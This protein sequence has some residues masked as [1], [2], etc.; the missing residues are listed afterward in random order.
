MGGFIRGARI[1]LTKAARNASRSSSRRQPRYNTVSGSF[2]KSALMADYPEWGAHVRCSDSTQRT[3]TEQRNGAT[4]TFTELSATLTN[5]LLAETVTITAR[6]PR[7]FGSK[8]DRLAARW[9][10]KIAKLPKRAAHDSVWT[11]S[12][13]RTAADP[14]VN[15][16]TVER[17]RRSGSY[18]PR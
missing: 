3:G 2:L 17:A 4:H 8:L 18:P 1:G 7:G 14:W 10:R 11:N 16:A 13:V 15:D 5:D 6:T 12:V 9:D